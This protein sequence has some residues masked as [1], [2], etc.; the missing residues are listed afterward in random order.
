VDPA[1]IL[2][3]HDER[4]QRY[5]VEAVAGADRVCLCTELLY[6]YARGVALDISDRAGLVLIDRVIE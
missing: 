1:H 5:R 2:L 6:G 4:A 3:S